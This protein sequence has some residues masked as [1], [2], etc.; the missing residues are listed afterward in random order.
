MAKLKKRA[1]RKAVTMTG[2]HMVRGT[3]AKARRSRL[4]TGSLLS[5]G[6]LLGAGATWMISR[7]RG[8][9]SSVATS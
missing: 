1:T 2:R 4:R 8:R 5:A 3:A 9:G 6:A 7:G